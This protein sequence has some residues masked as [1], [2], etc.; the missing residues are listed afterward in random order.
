MKLRWFIY[1]EVDG[2]DTD[3]QLQYWDE[4]WAYWSDVSTIWCQN[5]D[6][7]DFMNDKDAC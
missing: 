4:D 7:E 2:Q 6:V 5:A 1:R 3:P